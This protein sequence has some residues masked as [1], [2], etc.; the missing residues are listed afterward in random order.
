MIATPLG[1]YAD[2]YARDKLWKWIIWCILFNEQ[3]DIV[4]E[5]TEDEHLFATRVGG[6]P[7]SSESF[8]TNVVSNPVLDVFHKADGFETD[9][10][11]DHTG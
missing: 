3:D 5:F 7:E 8:Q 1:V 11:I 9:F 4:Q 2:G 6:N 10:K